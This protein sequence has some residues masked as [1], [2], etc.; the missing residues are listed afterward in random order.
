MLGLPVLIHYDARPLIPTVKHF[1]AEV[2]K[3]TKTGFKIKNLDESGLYE[4][5]LFKPGGCAKGWNTLT[6]ERDFYKRS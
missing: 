1:K 3:E 6:W 2:V 5:V 4:D